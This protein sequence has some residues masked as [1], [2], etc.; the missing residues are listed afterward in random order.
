MKGWVTNFPKWLYILLKHTYIY[1]EVWKIEYISPVHLN[2][3]KTLH[4]FDNLDQYIA[5]FE[6]LKESH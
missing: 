1:R 4:S 2:K 3:F 5:I 6:W